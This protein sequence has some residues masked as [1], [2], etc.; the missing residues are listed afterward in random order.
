[1]KIELLIKSEYKE[2]KIIVCNNKLKKLKKW[3]I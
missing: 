2:P 3:Y 1:M